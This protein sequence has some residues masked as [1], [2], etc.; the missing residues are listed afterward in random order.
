MKEFAHL[1]AARRHAAIRPS[2][3]GQLSNGVNGLRAVESVS[4]SDKEME[5]RHMIT[6]G[7]NDFL[8]V[9]REAAVEAQRLLE[10]V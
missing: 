8:R 4:A 6:R 3:G 9:T 1:S 7:L 2:A 10:H 5:M